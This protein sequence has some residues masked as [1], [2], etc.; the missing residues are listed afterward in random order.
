MEEQGYC[1][2]C[3][4]MIKSLIGVLLILNAF[5]W[6]RWNGIDGWFAFLGLLLI[7]GGVWKS[8]LPGCTCH[9]TCTPEAPAKKKK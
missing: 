4:G 6:P 3:K 5:V 9:K 7:L 2:K 1:Y 8:F